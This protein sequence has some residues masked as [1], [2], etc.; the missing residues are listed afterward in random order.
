MLGHRLNPVGTVSVINNA[1][2]L[3]CRINTICLGL[4][5]FWNDLLCVV[6]DVKVFLLLCCR[7][8]TDCGVLH[9]LWVSTSCWRPWRLCWNES[10]RCCQRRHIQTLRCRWH[11]PPNFCVTWNSLTT[12][13]DL[14]CLFRRTLPV[15][16]ATL[17]LLQT[18]SEIYPRWQCWHGQNWYKQQDCGPDGRHY[19]FLVTAADYFVNK[20][21]CWNIDPSYIFLHNVHHTVISYWYLIVAMELVNCRA[22]LE[23]I[24]PVLISL[25]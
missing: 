2:N 7:S 17:L 6:R 10:V 11:M 16:Q 13:L 22:P 24:G 12:P 19:A 3:I 9:L 15:G 25:S 5:S 14:S 18:H 20:K 23:S 8:W 1:I 4:V 21:C